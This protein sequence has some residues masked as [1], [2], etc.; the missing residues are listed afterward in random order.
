MKKRTLC[1]GVLTV[2][3]LFSLIAVDTADA[4][5]QTTQ[6]AL[7]K[8]MWGK[9]ELSQTQLGRIVFLKNVKLY[10]RGFDGKI[11]FHLNAKKGSMWRVHQITK[12]GNGYVYDLGG[13][14]RVQQ[15]NLSTYERVPIDLAKKMVELYGAKISWEK[16][17]YT[18]VSYPQVSRLVSKDAEDKIN[19]FVKSNLPKNKY[20]NVT[21]GY[22]AENA[23][24]NRFGVTRYTRKT[25]MFNGVEYT[26][27]IYYTM[28]FNLTTGKL[29]DEQYSMTEW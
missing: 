13:G 29:I 9:N 10:K 2:M 20:N 16:D 8:I 7:Q 22:R 19:V 3:I 11:S 18:D 27:T 25:E 26:S 17:S 4:S 23:G 15:T 5:T 28:V 24:D 6:Q 1:A 21:V 14:V 12:E